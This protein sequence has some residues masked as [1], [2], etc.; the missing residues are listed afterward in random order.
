MRDP[1]EV[2]VMGL[3]CVLALAGA[4]VPALI[5]LGVLVATIVD[6]AVSK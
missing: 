5:L 6:R 3:M 4:V 2:A 1:I